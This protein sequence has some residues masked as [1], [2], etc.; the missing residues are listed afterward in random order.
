M[1]SIKSKIQISMLS[2]VL[3]GS[4]LI[5][6]I[7]A[8]LNASGIDDVM[9][10]TLGPATQMAADAV[11]W[12]MGNY[13]TALQE[14]AASDIF[15]E[16]DPDAPELVP[17]REDIA[18]RNGFL[19]IGKMDASGFSS[20]GYSYAEEDY[21]QQCKSAMEPYISDIMNDGQ[22]MIFLLE[23]PIITNGRF[24]GVVYG[25]IS[26]D[27]LSDIVVSLAMGSDGVAYVLD[28]KGNVIGHRDASIVE[29]GSNMIEAAKSDPSAADVAAVNQRMIQGETGFG[30]YNFYGDNKFVGFAPIGGSQEW[31]IAIE[32]SQREL[33]ST[34]D[35]S[36]LL[37]VL[38]VILVLLATFPVAVKVGKSI[39]GPIQSCVARLEK[40][41]DGDLHTP[42]PQVRSKDETAQLA[43]ALE[44]MLS[45]LNDVAQDVTHHLGKIAQGDFRETITR[46]Y[47][48]DFVAME[49]SIKT[50]HTSLKDTL[51]QISQSAGTVSSS[52]VQVSNGAQSLSQGAA[53][54]ASAIHELSAT[55]DS[56][57]ENARQT[58]ATAEEA[59]HFVAQAGAQLG[60]SVNYVQELNTAME[61]ISNSSAEI[62]KII[63]TIENIA[64]QTNILALNAAVEAARAGSAGKGF[65]VVADEVRTL[66][67]KSDEA[68][69]ATKELI[70][71]SITAVA[72]GGQ[73]VAKVTESLDKTSSIADNVTIKVDAVVEAVESQTTAI[74]QVTEG[75]EQI[76]SVTQSNS[77]TSEQSAATAQELSDQSLLMNR[78]VRG[79]QL[80]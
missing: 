7:T 26:A 63:D 9:T 61:K 29:E 72:E 25:G 2:V 71:G 18:Q 39:S 12:K 22:Q 73:V 66:A 70:E 27:F 28:N 80:S 19:Y 31:S 44:T 6:V 20:T 53:E 34:L 32:T 65:A 75:I 21:F 41:A 5:G 23:V 38:V 40:M 8:L 51:S 52:A 54:Q 35:R 78:L 16:S 74:S 50:I 77:A 45:R 15:R 1:K 48:G 76:S 58:A 46:T 43:R 69:K 14:A 24:D 4:V 36:I 37:T 62:S 3:V 33:K 79:F 55:A 10:K 56:I 13:W 49:Q 30:S 59:G 42:S 68:A 57:A 17:L 11:E 67:S 64:F 47:W 60:V